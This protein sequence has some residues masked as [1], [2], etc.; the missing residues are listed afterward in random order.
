MD[1]RAQMEDSTMEVPTK[2]E[3]STVDVRG[4]SG[5][6]ESNVDN[7]WKDFCVVE[8][9]VKQWLCEISEDIDDEI[10]TGESFEQL[11]PEKVAA[12]RDEELAYMQ[13]R[14]LWRVVPIPPG[15]SPVSVRWVDVQKADGTTRSR[16]VARDFKGGDR[17]RDDLF[18]ATP[19]PGGGAHASQQGGHEHAHPLEA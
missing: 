16:L 7:P 13:K 14:G 15:V 12:A 10:E 19:P 4:D 11:D 18:A 5:S 3:G 17:G 6:G 8:E 9:E 2:I 1:V